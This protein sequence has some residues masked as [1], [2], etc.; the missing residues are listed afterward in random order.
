MC[1]GVVCCWCLVK[2]SYLHSGRSKVTRVTVG[3]DTHLSFRVCEVNLAT[4]KVATKL[5]ALP[6]TMCRSPCVGVWSRM[7]SHTYH[8]VLSSET[9]DT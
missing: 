9:F 1:V 8:P 3:R 4:L 5:R 7:A 2:K 6:C